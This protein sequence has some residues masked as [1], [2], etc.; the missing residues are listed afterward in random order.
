V[1]RIFAYQDIDAAR[2]T[3]ERLATERG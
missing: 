2:A 1:V 3:A